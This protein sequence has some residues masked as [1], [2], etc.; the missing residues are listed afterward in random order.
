M[1]S[2]QRRLT[3]KVERHATVAEEGEA[4]QRRLRHDSVYCGDGLAIARAPVAVHCPRLLTN[5]CKD[6]GLVLCNKA[7]MLGKDPSRSTAELAAEC[8]HGQCVENAD[9]R[10]CSSRLA[11]FEAVPSG[12]LHVTLDRG[13]IGWV[14]ALV[15]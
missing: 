5:V 10:S 9:G 2:C 4:H 14:Q 7:P 1:V 6:E 15:R 11:C 8:V 3:S 13:A 12:R